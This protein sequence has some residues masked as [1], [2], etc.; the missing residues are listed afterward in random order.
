MHKLKF[1]RP[2]ALIT[3]VFL[4]AVAGILISLFLFGTASF[5]IHE[6]SW[7]IFARP[8]VRGETAVEFPPFGSLTAQTHT[9]LLGLH[10]RLE[11]IGPQLVET[12]TL[13]P[14][15]QKQLVKDLQESVP[16]IMKHFFLRLVLAGFFG[17][18]I[19]A[20]LIWRGRYQLVLATGLL[21]AF[22][23]GV[24]LFQGYFTFNA[25]AFREPQYNGV[26]SHA[27]NFIRLAND[28]LAKLGKISDQADLL[29]GNVESLAASTDEL[30]NLKTLNQQG[31]IKNL[32]LVSD[33]HSNPVGIE[34]IK[35]LAS[36]FEI[37]MII[38]AGDLTDFGT[39][40]EKK[41][42]QDISGLGIPY[43]FS[44]GNHETAEMTKFIGQQPHVTLLDGSLKT[45]QGIKILGIPDPFSSSPEV[46]TKDP[47]LWDEILAST[48]EE[49]E[50]ALGQEESPDI[51]VV[52]NPKIAKEIDNTPPLVISGHT[53]RQ[54]RETLKNGS[55]LLNPGTTGAAGLRGLYNEG[56][57][58]YTAIIVHFQVGEGLLAADFIQYDLM[59]QRFS[60]ERRLGNESKGLEESDSAE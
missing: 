8:S 1:L 28:S 24:V 11:Q 26:I 19:L 41:I 38:D 12:D 27:P 3:A 13:T 21:A 23:V 60:L 56:S 29:I 58:P 57:V 43:I 20:F 45:I 5:K 59:S 55:L 16:Q 14:D 33:L 7:E 10:V 25:D 37:D 30:A 48:L 50:R 9:G 35:S 36:S 4:T 40:L 53:H 32:L 34:L 42:A 46:E 2:A 47:E 54:A 31:D 49:A 51:L 17:A 39:S 44:P 6:L 52:H 15:G 18:L 22:L